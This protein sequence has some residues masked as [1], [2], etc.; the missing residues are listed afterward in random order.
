MIIKDTNLP[1]VK[2]VELQSHNDNR[3]FFKETYRENIYKSLTELNFVQENHSRSYKN[4]L[5]GLHFQIMKPQGKLVSCINGQIFDVAVDINK[6]SSNFRKYFCTK[7]SGDDDLQLWIPP[8]YAHG[9]VVLSE[10][11]DVVY[12][13]TDYYDEDDDSGIRWD[14]PSINIP[15]PVSNPIVSNKDMKLKYICE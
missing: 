2:L 9:F 14:D 5:R 12:K 7:L 3:G 6:D 4:V 15:W 1:E 13:C 10:T 8:G 11:A